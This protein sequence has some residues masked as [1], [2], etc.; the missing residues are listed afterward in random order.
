MDDRMGAKIKTKKNPW[1]FQQYSNKSL[2]QKLNPKISRK[3][4]EKK[5]RHRAT[6]LGYTGTTTNL[7]IVLNTPKN[8]YLNQATQKKPQIENFKP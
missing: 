2:D 3:A 1:G 5:N 4:L 7:H 8:P 6:Q